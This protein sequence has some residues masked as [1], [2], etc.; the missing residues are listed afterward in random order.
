MT[1]ITI[2]EIHSLNRGYFVGEHKR[3]QDANLF[4][5]RFEEFQKYEFEFD[6][7]PVERI[8]GHIQYS[9]TGEAYFAGNTNNYMDRNS[10]SDGQLSLHVV[11]CNSQ[12]DFNQFVKERNGNLILC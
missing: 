11:R 3:E 5:I 12:F 6:S 10:V 1:Y 9:I 4:L 8:D 2:I 7:I